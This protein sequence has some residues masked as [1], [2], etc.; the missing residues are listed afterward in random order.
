[1]AGGHPSTDARHVDG[2]I[3]DGSCMQDILVVERHI[4]W[5]Q[6]ILDTVVEGGRWQLNRSELGHHVRLF[7]VG[8]PFCG[9]CRH[10]GFPWGGV[11][12]RRDVRSGICSNT[13]FMGGT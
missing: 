8:G 7:G 4:L 9:R 2:Q 3:V 12:R 10:E 1:M 11:T 6:S 5:M 13:L